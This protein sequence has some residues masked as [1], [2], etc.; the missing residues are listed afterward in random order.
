MIAR[1]AR[2]LKELESQAQVQQA[3]AVPELVFDEQ[4]LAAL[5]SAPPAEG[6]GGDTVP[7]SQG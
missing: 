1:E 7:A 6:S 4:Q 2:A 3:N 5:L